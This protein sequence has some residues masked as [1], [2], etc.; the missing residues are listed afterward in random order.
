MGATFKNPFQITPIFPHNIVLNFWSELGLLGLLAF[1]W[2]VVATALAAWR[3]WRRGA[4]EW[5]PL[6]LGVMLALLAVVVHGLV[7]VPYF[8][9]DLA[10]EFW[11]L[12]A[13]PWAAWRWAAAQGAVET[14]EPFSPPMSQSPG[15]TP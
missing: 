9:N 13:V 3:G 15:R 4:P 7:D 6:Q 12:V 2:I 11:G 10:L 5:R 1:G 8:K 14:R